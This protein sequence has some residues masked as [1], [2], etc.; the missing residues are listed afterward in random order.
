MLLLVAGGLW[1]GQ[2]LALSDVGW[3][4]ALGMILGNRHL[5]P[6]VHIL[7]TVPDPVLPRVA[8]WVVFA[9]Y[10]V[11][12][13]LSVATP[14]VLERGCSRLPCPPGT[15]T[16][17]APAWF[18][19]GFH[20]V[21]RSGTSLIAVLVGVLLIV[22]L[23]RGDGATRRAVAPTIFA[24][25][26][27]APVYVVQQLGMLGSPLGVW[28]GIGVHVLI[29]FSVLAGL[30]W[31]RWH[32]VAAADLVRELPEDI[33]GDALES[34]L[35]RCLGDPSLR[36]LFP[37]DSTAAN[38]SWLD[39]TG[40]PVSV[41][42]A[43]QRV[44]TPILRHGEVLALLDHAAAASEEPALLDAAIAACRLALQNARL[45]AQV[46]A[47]LDELERSRTRLVTAV[48][49]ERRRME[50]DLHDG[51]QAHL[52]AIGLELGRL[53]QQAADHER[54]DLR[55][56]LE[57]ARRDLE[58]AL[59]ELRGF[60]RGIHPAVLTDR[61]VPAALE[62]LAQRAPLPVEVTTRLGRYAAAVES[63]LYLVAA[64]AVTNSIRY[65]GASYLRIDAGNSEGFVRL[66]IVDDGQGG[67]E[68]QPGGGL[69]GLEDRVA[70]LG[71]SLTIESSV[72]LGTRIAVV[73]PVV[74]P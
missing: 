38:D 40:Q 47:Q 19:D 36:L 34:A 11:A 41:T 64:E 21:E 33:R 49:E 15:P 10:A 66:D 57:R 31:S 9:T 8:R 69:E 24:G 30:A 17:S 23:V 74:Q 46:Q 53:R 55:H 20:L 3:L 54:D 52:L 22:R 6:V 73:I 16:P 70:A 65:S 28:V 32:R 50:R 44:H 45:T 72:G 1:F 25:V 27:L 51:V 63:T 5:V 68:T 26:V 62:A 61:G 42:D 37:V 58:T 67:A 48:D 59:D 18:Q 7:L 60:A 14:F 13:A 2:W 43:P 39:P 71:G 12:A 35:G 4:F 29:P 56:G